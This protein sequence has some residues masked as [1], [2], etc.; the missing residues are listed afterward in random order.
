MARKKFW[1]RFDDYMSAATFAEAGE[2]EAARSFIRPRRTILL[3]L[4]PGGDDARSA[5]YARSVAARVGA[6]VE[7]LYVPSG[8][9]QRR[10]LSSFKSE[11]ESEDIP[12]RMVTTTG[13]LKK[14]IL[15]HTSRRSDIDFV[16]VESSEKLDIQCEEETKSL[17]DFIAA[18]RIPLVVVSEA[19]GMA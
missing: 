16:V 19:Q 15:E 6:G 5:A 13:C 4:T 2:A 14:R 10:F 17:K 7:L 11:L 18:L 8:E 12:F 3:V 1:E 9:K